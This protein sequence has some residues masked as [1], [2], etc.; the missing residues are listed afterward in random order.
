[1]SLKAEDLVLYHEN[2]EQ[3]GKPQK[4]KFYNEGLWEIEN[5]PDWD[6]NIVTPAS[7]SQLAHTLTPKTPSS[8]KKTPSTAAST[9]TADEASNK[10]K[11]VDAPEGGEPPTKKAAKAAPEAE[12]QTSRSG[13]VIKPKKFLD[14]EE[15]AAAEDCPHSPATATTAAS[16]ATAT[17]A[18]G[19]TNPPARKRLPNASGGARGGAETRV[20]LPENVGDAAKASFTRLKAGA[21]AGGLTAEEVKQAAADGAGR[22]QAAADEEAR[23][24]LETCKSKTL[25]MEARLLDYDHHYDHYCHEQDAGHG[26]PPAGL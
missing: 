5:N 16:D 13:R 6:P 26:G 19:N 10:R 1:G 11:R 17:P 12:P 24:C 8:T 14:G 20:Q 22:L 23:G 25:D 15:E 21:A 4:H 2:K 7:V 9:G 18:S 3:L